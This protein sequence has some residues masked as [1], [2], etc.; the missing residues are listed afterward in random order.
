MNYPISRI[1]LKGRRVLTEPFY[2]SVGAKDYMIPRFFTWNGAS[3]PRAFWTTTGSPFM[4]QF[5]RASIIHDWF[6]SNHKTSRKKADEIFL[7][8]LEEDG[9]G[10][11]TRHKMYRAVRMFGGKAWRN[12]DD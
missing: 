9:V 12:G 6:Y 10:W 3:I 7:D 2:F 11:Y 4:P 5:E 8:I 1:S